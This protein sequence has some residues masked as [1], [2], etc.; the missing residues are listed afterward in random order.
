MKTKESNKFLQLKQVVKL[1]IAA[2][3][4]KRLHRTLHKFYT[5]WSCLV[6]PCQSYLQGLT[7][8]SVSSSWFALSLR[9]QSHNVLCVDK[10]AL[11]SLRK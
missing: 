9:K 2:A 7:R 4:K 5:R 6:E 10:G 11:S 3:N 8:R 1:T